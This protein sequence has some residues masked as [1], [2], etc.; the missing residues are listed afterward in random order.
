M[1]K[2]ILFIE[3]E[4]NLLNSLAYLLEKEGFEVAK[5]SRGETGIKLAAADKPDLVLLDVNL[6]D[7]DGFEA[8]KRLKSDK[9]FRDLKIIMLTARCEPEDVVRGLEGYADDYMTKPFH[10]KVLVARINA[11]FRRGADERVEKG[12]MRFERLT[13]DPAGREVAVSEEP[14][15][16][17][18]TEYDILYLLAGRPARVF[19]RERIID[20][21]RGDDFAITDRIV[22]YQISNLRKKLGDQ[23]WRIETVRGIGYKFK[24]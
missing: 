24:V 10:P 22:D 20:A 16:L 19:S 9:N 17:T 23:G 15:K 5:A 21:V 3:D 11:L 13:I 14:I 4:E 8:A 18:K 6:P 12:I 7:L 1:K 2:K